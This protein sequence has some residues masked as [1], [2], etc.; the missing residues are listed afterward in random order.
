MPD[1]NEPSDLDLPDPTRQQRSLV[2]VNPYQT[3]QSDTRSADNM[4]TPYGPRANADVSLLRAALPIGLLGGL[5][6][7]IAYLMA[8]QSSMIGAWI[9]LLAV[10]WIG[11]FALLGAFTKGT[12]TDKAWKGLGFGLL[13]LPIYGLFVPVCTVGTMVSGAAIDSSGLASGDTGLVIGTTVAFSIVLVGFAMIT[14]NTI[15]LSNPKAP[16]EH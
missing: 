9:A 2:D 13:S 8:F 4:P 1:D 16:D 10:L 6:S 14:R 3:P 5:A 12:L 15:P 7:G 11:S